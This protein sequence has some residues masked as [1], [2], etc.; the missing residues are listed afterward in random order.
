MEQ[1]TEYN[2]EY[3]EMYRK[4]EYTLFYEYAANKRCRF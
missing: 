2:L 3:Y 1:Q 4:E